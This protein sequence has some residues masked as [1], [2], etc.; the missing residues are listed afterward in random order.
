MNYIKEYIDKINSKEI[1]VGKKV[2]K[3][4]WKVAKGKWW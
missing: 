3:N 2:K 4:I 1:I